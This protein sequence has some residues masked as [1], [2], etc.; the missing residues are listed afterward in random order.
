MIYASAFSFRWK[1]DDVE[2]DNDAD[3][4]ITL[5]THLK[6]H[7]RY[8][9]YMRTYTVASALVG[10]QSKIIYFITKPDSK[11]TLLTNY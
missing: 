2:A 11:C 6:P 10:A 8:A 7:T 9:V 1:V 3:E 4:V 5:L